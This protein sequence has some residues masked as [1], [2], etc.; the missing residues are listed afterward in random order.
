MANWSDGSQ[1]NL[2]VLID[3]V[4]TLGLNDKMNRVGKTKVKTA[5]LSLLETIKV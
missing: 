1:P 3:A 2:S 4:R 5:G